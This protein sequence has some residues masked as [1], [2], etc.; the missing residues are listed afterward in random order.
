M[1]NASVASDE[2]LSGIDIDD[3][4]AEQCSSGVTLCN[5]SSTS[6]GTGTSTTP[7]DAGSPQ[8][9]SPQLDTTG[10]WV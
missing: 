1:D 8:N 4:E 5:D 7:V 6:T 3:L 2:V 10:A 9:A